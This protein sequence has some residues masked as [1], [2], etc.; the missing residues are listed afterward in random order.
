MRKYTEL[1][2]YM[3][4]R[5]I[6]LLRILYIV[7]F[8]FTLLAECLAVRAL[9]R[10]NMLPIGY[11]ILLIGMFLLFAAAVGFLLF[12]KKSKR[13]KIAAF[14]LILLLICGSFVIQTVAND[15]IRTFEATTQKELGITTRAVYV[16][17]EN[18]A[19]ELQDTIGYTYG[20]VNHYDESC[21]QQVLA[22]VNRQTSAQVITAGFN[23]PTL[24]V[25]A[26]LEGRI[27]AAVLSGGYVSLLEESDGTSRFSDAVRVLTTVEVNE[28]QG[29]ASSNGPVE[30][31]TPESPTQAAVPTPSE[32]EDENVD[33]STLKPFIVYVSGSDSYEDEV[34]QDGRSDVN[35]LTVVNPLTK[36]ILLLNTPRD[37]YVQNTAGGYTRDKL[38]HCGIYGIGCSMETLGNLY[39]IQIDYY[40]RVNFSGFKKLIDAMGGITVY[41]DY[42]FTAITR[43]DIQQG[44]NHLT[45]QQA[46]DFARER[47]TL[48]G[49]DNE[50][51]KHQM[52]V[53]TA[54]IEKA[55]SGTTIISNYSDIMA[56]VEGMFTMNVPM[57]MVSNLMKMQLRDMAR[58]N[59]S[60][61]AVTGSDSMEEC[62]TWP[63][64]YLAVIIP[65]DSSV[66]KASRLIDMVYSGEILTEEVINSIS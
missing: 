38:T 37:Y 22:E 59:I 54:V 26:L 43:T 24:L 31:D 64:E 35:I 25:N 47:Y 60:S 19:E 57:E 8:L 10:L 33:Y 4:M 62:Y 6:P 2:C 66:S 14:V 52:Q 56:S 7:S 17:K 16:L 45:G 18:P 49:G 46:L 63:G 36:Q 9:I 42:A 3:N 30:S 58:W 51:G 48:P 34:I 44:E 65:S 40:V 11:L 61:F 41:S 55:T 27:D 50:R 21:T 53:I 39:D 28:K 12:F 1:R 32:P 5:K 15:V 13:S 23:N 29:S 20:Y